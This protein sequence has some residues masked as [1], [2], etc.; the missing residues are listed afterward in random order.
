MIAKLVV[1][2]ADRPTA[3]A[4]LAEAIEATEIAGSVT[5]AA[6]LAALA[7]D[8]DFAAGEV[9][10]GL[11]GRKQEALTKTAAPGDQVIASAVVAASGLG[12]QAAS[13]DPWATLAGYAH[14]H[15]LRKRVDLRFGDTDIAARL[16]VTADG[17]T[18]VALGDGGRPSR[19]GEDAR[20]A[21]WPG[22][23]TVFSGGAVFDFAVTDPFAKAAEAEAGTASLRAPMPGLVKLVRVAKGDT[24]VKGQAL[25]ILEAMKMEHTISAPHDGVIADI[26]AEGSQ[27]TDGTVLVRFEEV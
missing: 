5:N 16:L 10:T 1:H 15:P 3:L 27:I 4:A 11:I 24:V 9:D 2:A 18:E 17:P 13:L 8:A 12:E 19:P 21:R 26:A 23:V 14:F 25:L 20:V 6:F 7:R 22:H